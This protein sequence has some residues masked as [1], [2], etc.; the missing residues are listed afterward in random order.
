M[1]QLMDNPTSPRLATVMADIVGGRLMAPPDHWDHSW[2]DRE[3][4]KTLHDSIA[5]GMPFGAILAWRTATVQGSRTVVLDGRRRLGALVH[6]LGVRT[7]PSRDKPVY[8]DLVGKD[9]HVGD[10]D[11]P[12]RTWLPM[13]SVLNAKALHDFEK[14]LGD[15][16]LAAEAEGLAYALKDYPVFFTTIVTDD[17]ELVTETAIRA[18][19]RDA[20]EVEAMLESIP[21]IIRRG[22]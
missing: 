21:K 2:D 7:R 1:S 19:G 18:G 9:F 11:E 4:V 22:A 16:R 8:Y 5:R 10:H 13:A 12:P 15:E 20:A 17:I 14:R 6:S 3:K